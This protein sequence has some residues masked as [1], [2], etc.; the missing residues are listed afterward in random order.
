M[1]RERRSFAVISSM[2]LKGVERM[3]RSV[4]TKVLPILLLLSLLFSLSACIDRKIENTIPT[5][6]LTWA[7]GSSLPEAIDFFE[8]LPDGDAV[9]FAEEDP[10]G[11]LQSGENLISVIYTPKE[12]KK[13]TLTVKLNLI[14]DSEPPIISGAKDLM[15]YVGDTGV[16]YY[17]GVTVT[18]NCHGKLKLQADYALVDLTTEGEYPVT[19]YAYDHAGNVST[20]EITIHV[21]KEE[22]TLEMLYSKIDPLILELGLADMDKAD[23][24]RAIFQFVHTD[25]R[26]VYT[27]TSDKTDW[28][29]EAYFSLENRKGDCFSYFSLSKA[30]FER[31]GI[32]NL[33]VQRLPGF[34]DDTHY[35]S[36]IN[37]AEANERPVWYHYDATRLRD[38][39]YSG[40]LLTDAQIDAF[41][42]QRAYFYYYDRS[43]YPATATDVLTPRP[44]LT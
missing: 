36:M 42:E 35:W 27:D 33:D 19:Y 43:K 1:P 32:E 2:I 22:I 31:L 34:T 28:I 7:I 23:Q 13:Q 30:F 9:S 8:S 14:E 38:V 40:A 44:D 26:I 11:S 21:Y 16:A 29:R 15:A 24:A 3:K 41:C 20:A 39:S 5:K 6:D 37:I 17:A 25:A 12:G 4:L 18:D 10:W